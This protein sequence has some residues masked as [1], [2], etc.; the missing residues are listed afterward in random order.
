MGTVPVSQFGALLK[1]HRSEL[2]MSQ[3]QLAERSGMSA[4]AVGALERGS[5]RAPYR[6]TVA[7]LADAFGLT[8]PERAEFEVSAQRARGRRTQVE[9]DVAAT[10]N[11]PI[12]LTSFVGRDEDVAQ[13]EEL[14]GRQRLV[15][16]TGSGGVGKTRTASEVGL[17]LHRQGRQVCF[18]DL[19]PI[20]NDAFVFSE[21]ASVLGVSSEESG[22][23]LIVFAAMLK[24]RNLLLILDNCEHVI[25][26][27]AAVASAI[28]RTCPM[29]TIL[30]TSRERLA[31]DGEQV[32]RLPSLS[33]A[34]SFQVIMDRAMAIDPDLTLDRAGQRTIAEIC[35]R[36]EGIPL[37]LELAA[38]RLPAL[39]F[40][41][42]N[43]RLQ[44]HFLA[45]GGP[46]D[47]PQRQRTMLATIAWSYDLLSDGERL[48]LQRFTIFRGGATLDAAEAV[49]ADED[50]PTTNVA[51]ALTLL[52][53]KSLLTAAR[54][55]RHRYVMLESV[56][57]FASRKLHEAHQFD[58]IGR[59][60]AIWVATMADHAEATFWKIPATIWLDEFR[61]ELDNIR[62]A[63][64]WAIVSDR[65]DDVALAARVVAGLRGLWLREKN[66]IV[67]RNWAQHLIDRVEAGQNLA[68]A[69]RLRFAYIQASRGRA[70]FA[71][72]ERAIPL[73]E[74]GEE[75]ILLMA[76]HA[77][78]ASRRSERGEF[79]E[80][81]A[82]SL[83]ARD[84]A[85]ERG[86][87]KNARYSD[88]IFHC[89]VNCIRAGRF[90]DARRYLA[91]AA[92]R[93]HFP[94]VFEV[95]HRHWSAYMAFAEGDI[96]ESARLFE[97]CLHDKRSDSLGVMQTADYLVTV[98]LSLNDLDAAEAAGRQ[99]L[100][101]SGYEP[102]LAWSSIWHWSAVVARRGRP[103]A[104][105]RLSGFAQATCKQVEVSPGIIESSS[106][107]IMM[108]SL[109][110]QLP[111]KTIETLQAEG[112]RLDV[113]AAMDEALAVTFDSQA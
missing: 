2:G 66:L 79:A 100:K 104:A 63:V 69:V 29:I 10:H 87:E 105:A 101:L 9:P 102:M 50:L 32:Y 85:A 4:S 76:L 45:A 16:L 34:A 112:A 38:N 90:A 46:R 39:G 72:A 40:A 20:D 59:M 82:S 47:G 54:G 44:Q 55:K 49:C 83:R 22:T 53:E 71:A 91:E 81:D 17:G 57:A 6:D 93:T 62:S 26:A 73:F 48:L 107:A 42:L 25:D 84:L 86:L 94:E 103:H 106:Y 5:R 41:A 18:I 95:W 99:A 97:L 52:V 27:V 43:D 68:V 74:Q 65:D 36:L 15:T 80:A 64:E 37:A 110:E 58:R 3:E 35:R 111:E 56:R 24:A 23:S 67:F 98:R 30:A 60:H 12:R 28:V 13:I 8:G 70:V 51:S 75:W 33:M 1:R 109:C 31:I 11:L 108:R 78:V 7:L 21:I 96:R 61:P 19:S 89:G 92:Q 113:V 88:I 14:L 77:N